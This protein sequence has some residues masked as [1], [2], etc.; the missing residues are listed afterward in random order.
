MYTKKRPYI[1]VY[2]YSDARAQTTCRGRGARGEAAAVITVVFCFLFVLFFFS[3]LYPRVHGRD[4]KGERTQ[5]RKKNSNNKRPRYTTYTHVPRTEQQRSREA[6]AH[7][8]YVHY[9]VF[10]A[11]SRRFGLRTILIIISS[12][13]DADGSSER[14]RRFAVAATT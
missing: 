2:V 14:V 3:P 9:N 8:S 6:R 4:R 7:T 12:P 13:T 10:I 5:M 1:D 11:R